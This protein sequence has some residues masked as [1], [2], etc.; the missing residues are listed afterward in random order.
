MRTFCFLLSV[1]VL[2]GCG[3]GGG[4]GGSA[5]Q[6]TPRNFMRTDSAVT[7]VPNANP[8]FTATQVVTI[9]ND[10]AGASRGV[11]SLRN[12][13]GSIASSGASG[14]YQ[15]QVTL[16][17]D[18]PSEAQARE[19][20]ATMSVTHRDA[21]DP[22]TLYLDNEVQFAQYSANN[23]SRNATVAATLPSGLTYQLDQHGVAGAVTSSGL[24]GSEAHVDSVSGATTLSGTWDT[25]NVNAVSGALTVSG[26]IAD[27][28]TST[29]SGSLQVTLPCMRTTHATLDSTSGS[30]DA[31]VTQTAGV[32][33]DLEAQ[34]VSGAAAV[35]VAGT[36]P[37]GTQS[38]T[39]AHFRSPSYA[40][41]NPQ[42]T[43]SANNTS[44]GATIHD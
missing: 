34:T 23:V 10:D 38:A 42:V 25:A 18:A 6:G 40:T 9:S 30:I 12:P 44:G 43:V 39:H 5:S 13:G 7:V 4:G 36:T 41:S 20:L 27:L 35:A 15:I 24:H 2:A 11:V 31:T 14:G 19:A 22:G 16:S 33:F 28:Q 26:D 8:G 37:V 1:L 29:T 21:T 17:A 3:G 32:G